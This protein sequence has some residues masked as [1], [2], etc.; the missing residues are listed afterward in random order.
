M[1]MQ[2]AE[3]Y[4]VVSLCD[5]PKEIWLKTR[6]IK[7]Q[8]NKN[9]AH[10][11][12]IYPWIPVIPW[13]GY[14]VWRGVPNTK[15][16]PVPVV[17][18]TRSP[19]VF[20]YLWWTLLQHLFELAQKVGLDG[21]Y[22]LE[23]AGECCLEAGNILGWDWSEYGNELTYSS[24]IPK[25][26]NCGYIESILAN[27]DMNK[28]KELFLHPFYS[29]YAQEHPDFNPLFFWTKNLSFKNFFNHLHFVPFR[30]EGLC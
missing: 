19:W 9:Y 17:P 22:W 23:T 6:K 30:Q 15:T 18:V 21:A 13:Y 26:V 1:C 27:D 3:P 20:P 24:S 5:M 28:C 10:S 7:F 25:L 2:L 12:L 11:I 29:T 4:L 16:V 14:T 8:H